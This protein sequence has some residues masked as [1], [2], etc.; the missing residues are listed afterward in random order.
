M[1][2]DRFL[3]RRGTHP[4]KEVARLL[5]DGRVTVDAA[6][7]TSGL[8]R[9]NRFS[10]VELDGEILQAKESIYLMLHKPAGYLSATSDP[11]HPTV[12]ARGT[13]LAKLMAD[14]LWAVE[15]PRPE[16]K[17]V[18]HAFPAGL[19]RGQPAGFENP[20]ERGAIP[21]RRTAFADAGLCSSACLEA[22]CWRTC[23]PSR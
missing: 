5:A 1:R 7:E 13:D 21:S 16:R 2:L 3:T 14:L 10:R 6:V 8:R 9:I 20:G 12:I 19:L 17:H 15:V 4:C 11:Q 22:P 18:L 23:A